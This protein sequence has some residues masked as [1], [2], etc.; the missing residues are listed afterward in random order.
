MR[1]LAAAGASSSARH[2][3]SAAT[4]GG[5]ALLGALLG[6]VA[7]YIGIIGWVRGSTLTG[8]LS[9]LENVP[10]ANLL[11]ILVGMPAVAAVL[12]WVLSGRERPVT[13]RR[14]IE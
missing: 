7:G 1:V 11:V 12:G 9:F 14:A 6:T 13:V 2:A 5:L 10:V 4:A 3:L 8:G